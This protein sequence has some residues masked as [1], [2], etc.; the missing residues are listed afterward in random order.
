M[1]NDRTMKNNNIIQINQEGISFEYWTVTTKLRWK[2]KEISMG[3]GSATLISELQQLWQSNEGNVK[4][5][6]VPFVE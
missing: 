5:E 1:I 4:W 3:D 2:Q 6:P